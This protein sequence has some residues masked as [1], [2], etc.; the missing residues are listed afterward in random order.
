M[1]LRLKQISLFL[2]PK[3]GMYLVWF[4]F[5]GFILYN[6]LAIHS[7][8]ARYNYQSQ[9]FSD[10]AGYQ[11]YLPSLFYYNFDGNA[12]PDSIDH[13]TGHGFVIDNGRIISKYPIGVS[14]LHLPFFSLAMLLESNSDQEKG[15]SV[16]QHKALDWSTSFYVALGLLLLFIVLT[17]YENLDPLRVFVGLSLL[18]CCSNLL[19]YSTRDAGMSHGYSFFLFSVLLYVLYSIKYNEKSWLF[20]II[21][22]VLSLIFLVRH[23]NIVFV[24][25]PILFFVHRLKLNVLRLSKGKSVAILLGLIIAIGLVVLQLFYNN[26]AFGSFTLDSYKSESFTNLYNLDVAFLLIAPDTGLFIY[27]PVYL[28][29]LIYTISTHRL[30]LIEKIILVLGFGLIGVVYMA[31]S[32]PG[33]GCAVGHR[34]YTEHLAYFALPFCFFINYNSRH[35]LYIFIVLGLVL[36]IV[37]WLLMSHF[38]GCWHGDSHYD[39]H[40]FFKVLMEKQW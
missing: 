16:I 5:F 23:I 29:I 24:V 36:G 40:Y 2:K 39:W 18:L 13:K 11:V 14:C 22:I 25:I 21:P 1:Y 38:D 8:C 27:S 26:Y 3:L 17:R 35:W 31:W 30:Q 19:Y 10:K 4:L 37:Y 28:A 32:S 6:A 34:G 12:M 15:Y 9:I 20:F 33:L 7:H